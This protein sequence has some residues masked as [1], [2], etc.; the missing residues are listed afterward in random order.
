MFDKIMGTA[1]IGQY[2]EQNRS[3]Q[4]IEASYQPQ[5]EKF[6]REREKYL[7]Y[8]SQPLQWPDLGKEIVVFVD[9]VPV[10]FDVAP[11]SMPMTGPWC[12]CGL[13]PRPWGQR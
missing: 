2:L 7:I 3:P 6:K 1:T 4:E 9:G 5:L 11:I 8:G 13:L 10:I 12:P